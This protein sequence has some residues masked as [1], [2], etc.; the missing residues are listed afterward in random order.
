[1]HTCCNSCTVSLTDGCYEAHLVVGQFGQRGKLLSKASRV[2]QDITRTMGG[3][4]RF[5]CLQGAS[6]VGARCHQSAV[7]SGKP[8][9]YGWRADED[10]ANRRAR[11]DVEVDSVHSQALGGEAGG[12]GLGFGVLQIDTSRSNRRIVYTAMIQLM[13]KLQ[14]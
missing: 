7:P 2:D 3:H 9:T 6:T 14:E 11:S 10:L 8:R 4:H 12:G 5:E 13:M 1:M